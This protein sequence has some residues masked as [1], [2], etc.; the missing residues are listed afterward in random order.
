M[1]VFDLSLPLFLLVALVVFFAALIKGIT[2]FGFGLVATPIL[3]LFLDVK[4]VIAVAIP[5]HLVISSLILNQVW[6][7]LEWRRVIPIVVAAVLGIPLGTF[8]LVVVPSSTL[9]L[10]VSLVVLVAALALLSGFTVRI[11]RERLASA[12]AGFTA[13]TLFSSTSIVGPPLVIFMVNQGWGITAFRSSLGGVNVAME[14][15]TL[16]SFAVAGLLSTQSL[17]LDVA[18]LPAVLVSSLLAGKLVSRLNPLLFRRIAI[19][20]VLA[21]GIFGLV[22]HFFA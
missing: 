4:L 22:S 19:L 12:M 3:M 21:S 10:T 20:L 17:G 15:I 18:L 2:G 14:L 1:E 11:A 9:R 13:G 7:E 8:I 6:R 5:L 16:L